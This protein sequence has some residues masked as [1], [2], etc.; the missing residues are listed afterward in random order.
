VAHVLVVE[1]IES[2]SVAGPCTAHMVRRRSC[3]LVPGSDRHC[4]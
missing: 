2:R 3:A 4:R 1:R